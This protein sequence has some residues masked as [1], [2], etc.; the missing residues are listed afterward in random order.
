MFKKP[1]PSAP[2]INQAM[3]VD[4]T[5]EKRRLEQIAIEAG[6]SRIVAKRIVSIYFEA[7]DC[8][9]LDCAQ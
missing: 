5:R 7:L 9:P 1:E 4:I 2:L 6:V 3:T 8:T